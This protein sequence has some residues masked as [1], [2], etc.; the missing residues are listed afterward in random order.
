MLP[1]ILITGATSFTGC[2]IA[3]S[4]KKANYP[5]VGTLTRYTED[6]E[7]D[8]I[9]KNRKQ[10][11]QIEEWMPEFSVTKP[12]T[13]SLIEKTGAKVWVGHGAPIKGYRSQDFDYLE[14]FR[15][16]IT[17]LFEAL[18]VFKDAGGEL[19]IHTGTV[20]EP[21]EGVSEF[22]G[23]SGV[24]E[25]VSPYG[26]SKNLVWNVIRFYC[27]RL[28]ISV[29]KIVIPNPIGRF[30]NPDRLIPVFC[31]MW[32]KKETPKMKV[33]HLIRDQLP[34]EW[35]AQ[36]YIKEVVENSNRLDKTFRV[37]IKRP[38]GFVM[39]QKSFIELIQKEFSK[40]VS[41]LSFTCEFDQV[42]S[43]EPMERFN[44][45]PVPELNS[46]ESRGLFFDNW[47]ESLF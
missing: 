35:L 16:T 12:E 25:G 8:P 17:G 31:E 40:R 28:G 6:Y 34:A 1:K 26:L 4:F 44:T 43:S 5:V 30:E 9:V 10:F 19:Y 38:S 36:V 46:S 22:P 3:R 18:K 13:L 29:S 47:A 14:S 7:S 23:M 2:H 15:N 20:F 24:S 37:R 45:E 27:F 39:S 21:D 11:S 33:G 32:K 42:P 41:G